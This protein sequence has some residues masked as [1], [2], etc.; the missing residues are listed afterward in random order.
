MGLRFVMDWLTGAKVK[1]YMP[2]EVLPVTKDNSAKF[3]GQF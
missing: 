2:T 1:Q 3:K